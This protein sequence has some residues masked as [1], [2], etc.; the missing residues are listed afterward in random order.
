M[1]ITSIY[2]MTM[3]SVFLLSCNDDDDV[4]ETRVTTS[5]GSVISMDGIWQSD[6]IDFTDYRLAEDFDFDG[7]QLTISIY[8]SNGENC[9][10][11]DQ[12]QTVDITFQVLGTIE[13]MLDGSTVMANKISGTQK[14]SS[15]TEASDF[16]QTFYI[17]EQGDERA[18][19]HGIFGDDGGALSSD[20]FPVEL[21]PFAIRQQ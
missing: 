17:L 3:L 9:D 21:H 19:Y 18:L 16:K 5:K 8:Q 12:T 4:L 10:S 2:F 14:S 20:G 6:C 11:P 15:D 1:R 7:D 13:A